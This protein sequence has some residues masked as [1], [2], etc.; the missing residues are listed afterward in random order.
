MVVKYRTHIRQTIGK[1]RNNGCFFTVLTK[2]YY[3]MS[4]YGELLIIFLIKYVPSAVKA[5]IF[6]ILP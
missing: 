5:A 4:G 1:S 2:L 3:Y 6:C